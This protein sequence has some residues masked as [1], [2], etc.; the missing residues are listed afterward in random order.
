MLLNILVNPTAPGDGIRH[1]TI[2]RLLFEGQSFQGWGDFLYSGY[3]STRTVDPWFLTHVL[4]T[5]LGAFDIALS[6]ELLILILASA[7]GISFL[8][9]LNVL[10]VQSKTQSVLVALLLLGNVQFILRLLLGRPLF[11]MVALSM[12]VLLAIIHR[13][14]V[15]LLP[16]MIVTTLLSHLF[17]FPLFICCLGFVWLYSLGE[18]SKAVR[19]FIYCVLGVLLGLILHPQTT[20][21]I[22]YVLTIFLKVPFQEQ[23][24]IGTEMQPGIGNMAPIIA[25]WGII[26]LF[27]KVTLESGTAWKTFHERGITLSIGIT[28]LMTVGMLSWI[29]MLDFLWP[30]LLVLIAQLISLRPQVAE[31]TA[32]LIIP[33]RIVNKKIGLC[34]LLLF[35]TVHTAKAYNIYIQNDVDRA[36]VHFSEPLKNIPRAARVLN[37]DWDLFPSLFSVRPDLLYARGM[38][39]SYDY[40]VDPYLNQ[41]YAVIRT[42]SPKSIQ[43]DVWIEELQSNVPSDY[44]ALWADKHADVIAE[45]DE[46]DGIELIGRSKKLVVYKILLSPKREN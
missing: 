38:D 4:L 13:R 30:L 44:L 23:L 15:I 3:F 6:Q 18:R 19:V 20:N 43:W 26:A 17:V 46:I 28:A 11:L 8:I 31:E 40:L 24:H 25:L 7:V 27:V 34:V 16:M 10:R 33:N 37:V 39:P 35:L 2:A 36:P 42:S 32:R 1:L 14:L 21:Y 29:R 41:L 5:P 45:L 12:I 22:H 9:S